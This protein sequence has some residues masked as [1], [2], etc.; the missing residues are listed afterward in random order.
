M[1]LAESVAVIEIW[2]AIIPLPTGLQ[3]L[4]LLVAFYACA[5]SEKY[6]KL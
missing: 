5:N 2:K 3:Q 1:N 4:L 6:D